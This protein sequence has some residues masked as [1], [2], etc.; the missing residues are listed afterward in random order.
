MLSPAPCRAGRRVGLSPSLFPKDK[1][2]SP[3]PKEKQSAGS[4]SPGLA[5]SLVRPQGC[6]CCGC[7]GLWGW[8]GSCRSCQGT[9]RPACAG[10]WSREDFCRSPQGRANPCVTTAKCL[11]LGRNPRFGDW[12]PGSKAGSCTLLPWLSPPG[13]E[14]CQRL[15]LWG[16]RAGQMGVGGRQGRTLACGTCRGMPGAPSCLGAAHHPSRAFGV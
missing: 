4:A 13:A 9:A 6:G 5:G 16:D 12:P 14:T 7:C 2:Q 11:F 15:S 1:T 8:A 3:N 10:L